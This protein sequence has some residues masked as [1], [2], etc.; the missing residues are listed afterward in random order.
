MCFPS[1]DLRFPFILDGSEKNKEH[2]TCKQ[3]LY[4]R[5]QEKNQL[6]PSCLVDVFLVLRWFSSRFSVI[7]LFEASL[8]PMSCFVTYSGLAT[9]EAALSLY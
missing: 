1:F 4:S 5:K 6:V 9:C 8:I 2:E 3:K 7:L